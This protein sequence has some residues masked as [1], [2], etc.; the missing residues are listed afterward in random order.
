MGGVV[1]ELQLIKLLSKKKKGGVVREEEEAKRASRSSGDSVS[2]RW[3]T[4]C[5]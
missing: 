4:H 2:P 1:C 3:E 5:L